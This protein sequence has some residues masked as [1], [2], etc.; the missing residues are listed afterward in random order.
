MFLIERHKSPYLFK[1]M[2]EVLDFYPLNETPN[3]AV[4]MFC[5]PEGVKIKDNFDTPKCFNF[6][7]TDEVGQRTY[8]ST[9]YH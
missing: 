8:G 9:F 4:A 7:L 1:Y 3:N 5:F 2:P 6:V